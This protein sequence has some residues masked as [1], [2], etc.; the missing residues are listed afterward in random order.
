M[1]Q[2]IATEEP[3]RAAPQVQAV[4][5]YRRSARNRQRNLIRVQ[6]HMICR[7]AEQ[8]GITIIQEFP[9][10][11]MSGLAAMLGRFVTMLA[12]LLGQAARTLSRIAGRQ[13]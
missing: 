1:S 8:R 4:A 13:S 7:W 3:K 6:Q 5:Y 10:P 12:G 2:E 9:D 11:G